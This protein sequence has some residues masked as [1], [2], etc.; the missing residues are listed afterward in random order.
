MSFGIL[1]G[2][3]LGETQTFFFL[4]FLKKFIYDLRPVFRTYLER[5]IPSNEILQKWSLFI[6]LQQ[7]GENSDMF[8]F[9]VIEKFVGDSS[10]QFHSFPNFLRQ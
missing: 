1:L 5:F 2:E 4:T 10:S 8:D 6:L 7:I 3:T 9:V